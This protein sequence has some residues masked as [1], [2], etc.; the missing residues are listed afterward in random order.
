MLPKWKDC[1]QLMLTKILSDRKNLIIQLPWLFWLMV[2]L[3][4]SFIPGDQ[5]PEVKIEW[6]EIDT[7]VH[8][9]MYLGLSFLMLIGF[10]HVKNELFRIQVLYSVVICIM[11]GFLVELIQGYYIP[12]RFFSWRDV[13]ANGL[14]SILGF[15]IFAIYRKK[16]MNLVRF[17]K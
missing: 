11:I 2:V 4:L 5:L 7:V 1:C 13:V 14:G 9:G 12:N 3:V 15:L 6:L 10:F 16:D 8:I 17:L